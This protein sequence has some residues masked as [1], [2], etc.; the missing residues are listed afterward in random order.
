MIQGYRSDMYK[1]WFVVLAEIYQKIREPLN[2]EDGL[3][4]SLNEFELW[5][6]G[7]MTI[8]LSIFWIALFLLL[9]QFVVKFLVW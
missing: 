9:Q 3:E 2:F 4:N 5:P 8:H 7:L 6:S 1:T